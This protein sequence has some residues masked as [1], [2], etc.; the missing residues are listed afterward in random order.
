[1]ERQLLFTQFPCE[2]PR[3]TDAKIRQLR[4]PTDNGDP[5]LL[6]CFPRGFRSADTGD[7]SPYDNNPIRGF[8]FVGHF[9]SLARDNT[10]ALLCPQNDLVSKRPPPMNTEINFEHNKETSRKPGT[11]RTLRINTT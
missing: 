10:S 5:G 3:K 1:M 6:I 8:L 11:D 9:L 2:K 7:A 4:F